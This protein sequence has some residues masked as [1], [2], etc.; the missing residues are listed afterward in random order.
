ME[1]NRNLKKDK[2]YFKKFHKVRNSDIFK[3]VINYTKL[4]LYETI[5][6]KKT[7]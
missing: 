5:K 3:L 1:Q 7:Y 4:I 6:T 2:G